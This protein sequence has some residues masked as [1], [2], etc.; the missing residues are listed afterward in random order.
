MVSWDTRRLSS[1][2]YWV[3]SQ[4]EICCGDQSRISLLATIFRNFTWIERR[5][6]LGR[7]ADS[8]ASL[9]AWLARYTERPQMTCDFPAHGRRPSV[10][11]FGNLA[12]RRARNEP[13]RALLALAQPEPEEPP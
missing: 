6:R 7:K 1:S 4:P 13:S 3:F 10:Q 2:G 9:S 8:Q 12:N 11:A 5:H